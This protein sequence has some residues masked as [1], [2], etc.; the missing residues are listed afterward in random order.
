M[1][2]L[3]LAEKID[4]TVDRVVLEL[5]RRSVAV[6]RCDTSDF[7]TR[8]SVHGRLHEG[9]WEGWLSSGPRRLPFADIRSVWCRGTSRFGWQA[10]MSEPERRHAD[11]ETRLGLGGLLADLPV[12]W[13]NHPSAEADA[14]YKPR[15]LVAAAECGLNVPDT[16]VTAD[17][18]EVRRFASAQGPVVIKPLGANVLHQG[19][20]RTLAHTHL[21]TGRDLAD[22]D[23][24]GTN[25][26]LI[27]A[28]VDKD[29]EVRLTAVGEALFA[30]AI[31]ACSSAARID[32]RRD[33]AA[34]SYSTC[35]VPDDVQAGVLRYLRRF[36]LAFA[37]FDFV[38]RPDGGW[39][40]LEANAGGQY[41]WIEQHTGLPVSDAV[42]ELLAAPPC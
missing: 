30:A 17:P 1:T 40:F 16:I 23:G 39:V 36:G 41:G 12:R 18:A 11:N 28:W 4:A 35:S 37:A 32:W 26:H 8:A 20:V 2:V 5:A 29:Y 7:P 31:R 6:V 34:L 21:L 3:V 42:A 13:L 27:Q 15:Q 24:V 33:Y 10:G 19:S 25:P 22:L 38:V 9:R 14:G